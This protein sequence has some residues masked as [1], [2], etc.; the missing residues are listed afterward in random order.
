VGQSE[1]EINTFVS[2]MPILSQLLKAE[3]AEREVRSI[4][5]HMC[6]RRSK[7]LP[8]FH[9]CGSREGRCILW[10]FT[11][12]SAWRVPR[13]CSGEAFQHFAR[14]SFAFLEKF[15]EGSWHPRA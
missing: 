6:Q 12:K 11:I 8:L 14:D 7:I 9:S 10:N 13:A 4:A 15:V 3:M 1:A 5:Y 2:A